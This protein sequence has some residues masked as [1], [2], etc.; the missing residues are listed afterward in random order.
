VIYEYY[1]PDLP[2]GSNPKGGSPYYYKT[3]AEILEDY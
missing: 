3:D 2:M 1:N